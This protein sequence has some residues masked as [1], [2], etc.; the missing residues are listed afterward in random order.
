MAGKWKEVVR[1]TF[2]GERFRDH[3]LD[4]QALSELSQFQKMV[5]ET[6]KTLWR[7]ANPD[8]ERLPSHFEERVRLCLRRIEDGSAT[9]PLEVFIEE[10]DQTAFWE[11]EPVEINEAVKLAHEVYEAI[12]ADAQLPERFPRALLPEYARWGQ[13]LDGDEAVEMQVSEKKPAYLTLANRQKLEKFVETP[14]EDRVEI[15]GEVF[16]AD[17]KKGR[18]QL[19]SGEDT[20]VT[21]VFTPE[22]EDQVTTALKEHKT[23]RMFVKGSGEYSPQG[24][25]LRVMQVD[26]LRLST[27]ETH[28]DKSARPIED[29]LEELARE[30]PQEEWDKLPSDLNDNLDHYLYGVPKQ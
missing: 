4:L 22:Q 24:K 29:L 16:E 25:L 7:A 17:V 14:H 5:A 26:E 9:A 2:K 3:A 13:S 27:S 20:A 15:R 11:P 23:A 6:A 10:K 12:G 28:Y 19:W 8:R 1:L 21:A 18:F 30:I